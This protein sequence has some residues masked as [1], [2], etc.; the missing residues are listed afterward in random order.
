MPETDLT[1]VLKLLDQ[2]SGGIKDA[3][4]ALKGTGTETKKVTDESEK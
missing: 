4:N 2:A 3:Q 1:I